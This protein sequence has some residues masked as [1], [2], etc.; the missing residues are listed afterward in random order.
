VTSGP[1]AARGRGERGVTLVELVVSMAVMAILLGLA[2]PTL[3]SALT[4]TDRLQRTQ[5]AIDAAK[6]VSAR[7]DRELRSAQCISTPAEN[8]SGN[9]LVFRTLAN[10]TQA[11]VTY[12]VSAGSVTRQQDLDPEEVLITNVGATTSAFQQLVTPLRTVAVN[13]P[14][15]SANGGSFV[16]QTTI[17]GRNAWRSC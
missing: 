9:I 14:I 13:I 10:G 16:L 4:S 5:A 1:E 12:R 2:G 11:T 17:A 7:L 6:L 15:R 3:I 8:A